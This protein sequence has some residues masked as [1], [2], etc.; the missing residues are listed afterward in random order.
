MSVSVKTGLH[1]MNTWKCSIYTICFPSV[2]Y[3]HGSSYPHIPVWNVDLFT[4]ERTHTPTIICTP[5]LFK[6]GAAPLH[7]CNFEPTTVQGFLMMDPLWSGTCWSSFKYFIILII[8]TYYILC[9][10][11]IIKCLK[12]F[13]WRPIRVTQTAIA[14]GDTCIPTAIW[15]WQLKSAWPPVNVVL[16]FCPAFAPLSRWLIFQS[17]TKTQL[18]TK[19]TAAA[20][21]YGLHLVLASSW[22][23]CSC[24][25]AG[26]SSCQL[27]TCLVTCSLCCC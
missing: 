27:P 20:Q 12:A 13:E 18:V 3:T 19:Y 15:S 5:L 1:N 25:L 16:H 23:V 4:F 22:S 11:W 6:S 21:W 26:T 8:S 2:N 14:L 24:G 7:S 9:I 10:I 17:C